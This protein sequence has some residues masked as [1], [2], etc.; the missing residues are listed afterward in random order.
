MTVPCTPKD[1][2]ST[3]KPGLFQLKDGEDWHRP[4]DRR[5]RVTSGRGQSRAE[6]RLRLPE[7]DTEPITPV[8]ES[9]HFFARGK[10]F[11]TQVSKAYIAGIRYHSLFF[12]IGSQYFPFLF[13]A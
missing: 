3:L 7:D 2:K 6:I 10:Q 1:A 12:R 8:S 13:S 4:Q 11:G 9:T 5:V